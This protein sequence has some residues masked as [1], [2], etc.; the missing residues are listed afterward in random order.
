LTIT[1]LLGS[2]FGNILYSAL[3]NTN[4]LAGA[5]VRAV[6][7]AVIWLTGIIIIAILSRSIW[8]RTS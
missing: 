7:P 1:L 8:R 6:A 4:K 5:E 3:Y 2:W